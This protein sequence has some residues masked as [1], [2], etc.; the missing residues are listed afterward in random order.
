MPVFSSSEQLIQV[1]Q[2]L[3]GRMAEKNPQISQEVAASKLIIRFLVKNPSG[4]ITL[5]GR[6]NP[7]QVAYGANSFRPDLQVELSGDALHSILLGELR[8]SKALSSGQM[9]V[10]GSLLKSFALEDIF[11]QC[12]AIYPEVAKEA[13]LTPN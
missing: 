11:H 13:G 6:H 1:F 9:K 7:V 3:F 10:K 4:I 12:Q 5:N 2:T 8:L